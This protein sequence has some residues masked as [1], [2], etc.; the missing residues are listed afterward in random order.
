VE[1]LVS[2]A[3]YLASVYDWKILVVDGGQ[4]ASGVNQ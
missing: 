3:T 1:E 4:L 2:T